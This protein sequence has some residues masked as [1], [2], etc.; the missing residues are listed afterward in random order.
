MPGS[1]LNVLLQETTCLGCEV[2]IIN[3]HATGI[4]GIQLKPETYIESYI[5]LTLHHTC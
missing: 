4:A 3:W 2:R 5:A 1:P